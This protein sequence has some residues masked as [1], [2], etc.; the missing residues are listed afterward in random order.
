MSYLKAT[1]N[2][3]VSLTSE[4]SDQVAAIVADQLSN[5]D[6]YRRQAMN[7]TIKQL[8]LAMNQSGVLTNVTTAVST[9]T[10][11]V[12]MG[13]HWNY[14]NTVNR[15]DPWVIEIGTAIGMSDSALDSL[16]SSALEI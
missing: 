11:P 8:R 4:D 13:I 9:A 14:S 10:D 2:G 1:K 16:F 7:V 6:L 3:L 5:G 15:T 12:E